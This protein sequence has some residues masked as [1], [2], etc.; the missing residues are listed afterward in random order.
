[1]KFPAKRRQK[2]L[3]DCSGTDIPLKDIVVST[4]IR[5]ARNISGCKFPNW[6]SEEELNGIF[7]TLST[8]VSDAAKAVDPSS[9]MKVY[10]M[11][12][13]G[14][15]G[16][17]EALCSGNFIS[18]ELLD[19]PPSGAGFVSDT[20]FKTRSDFFSVMINEEDHLRI[21]H[22][23]G[24]YDL[25]RS[26]RLADELD[27]E[28]GKRVGYAFN[29][30]LGFLTACPSNLG[31]GMRASVMLAVHG[32]AM[33]NEF[34]SSC[35]AV[36][37]LG[38]NVRGCNGE[39]TVTSSCMIQVSNRGTLGLSETRVLADLGDVV[40]ELILQERKARIYLMRRTPERLNDYVAR[41]VAVLQS[42]RIINS[43][44][45]VNALA[46][47][48]F[49]ISLGMVSGITAAKC[50]KLSND[51]MP[52]PVRKAVEKKFSPEAADNPDTRDAFRAKQLRTA[53]KSAEFVPWPDLVWE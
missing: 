31:T 10:R 25:M 39:S 16:A 3:Q 33:I 19:R 47:V 29:R 11:D 6:C 52:G 8:A 17:T 35:R 34:D 49:G 22:F 9:R 37:R 48:E 5:L 23:S 26:W 21:Q 1:M 51:S 44:D 32:L 41:A 2:S 4:R 27:T 15:D 13:F 43:E 38:F 24:E 30:R 28:I 42:A 40:D 14:A 12:E 53:M 36:D 20:T 46:A 7:N 45:A 18:K 50:R